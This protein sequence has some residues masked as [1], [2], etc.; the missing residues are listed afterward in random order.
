MKIVIGIFVWTLSMGFAYL[1]G[2]ISFG[3]DIN[4]YIQTGE[5]AIYYVIASLIIAAFYLAWFT[6]RKEQRLL[7]IGGPIVILLVWG[8]AR[9]KV[10][11]E[12]AG[13]M[14]YSIAFCLKKNYGLNTAMTDSYYISIDGIKEFVIFVVAI[15]MFFAAY[16]IYRQ[17]SL[18]ISTGL[19]FIYMSFGAVLDVDVSIPAVALTL[20]SII[21]LRYVVVRENQPGLSVYDAAGHLIIFAV[22]IIVAAFAYTGIY[23]L[24]MK[25]QGQVVSFADSIEYFLMGDSGH[26]YSS[27]YRINDKE[28]KT[29]DEVVDELV[30][31]VPPEGNLYVTSRRYVVYEDGVWRNRDIGYEVDDPVYVTFDKVDF[32]RYIDEISDISRGADGFSY[33]RSEKLTDYIRQHISYTVKPEAFDKTVDPVMYALYTGHQ[34]YCIHFATAAAIGLRA[35]GVQTR[36]STGYVVPASAWQQLPD[37]R[38]SAKILDRY[39]HAW[40]EAYDKAY[41]VWTIVDATPLGDMA[42]EFKSPDERDDEGELEK[43]S[44]I[45]TEATENMISEKA[46]EVTTQEQTSEQVTENVAYEEE[47]P[48]WSGTLP[49]GDDDGVTGDE[50][51]TLED[52]GLSELLSGRPF[53]V[54]VTILLVCSLT[55][56][57]ISLRRHIIVSRRRKKLSGRNRILSVYEMSHA[58]YEMLEFSGMAVPQNMDDMEYAAFVT[59]NCKGIKGDEFRRFVA[60][61]QAA[62]YGHIPPTDRELTLARRLYVKIRT[63]LYLECNMRKRFVWKY[64]KCYDT[65]SWRKNR[66]RKE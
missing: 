4:K 21:V 15:S 39:S 66:S 51:G 62:V 2:D 36:Y 12:G 61:V 23:E 49:G 42:D 54:F 50:G 7:D 35:M 31:D 33:D 11:A 22:C 17:S 25:K 60:I 65:L 30:R 55:F 18:M 14:L 29:T 63:Y 38:Y 9:R 59:E 20:L 43:P 46:T 48:S 40:I 57:S 45:T 3:S 64:I 47:E 44:E 10:L 32:G 34:G 13:G 56:L 26:G 58:I 5:V 8:L 37:G 28:V 6:L 27:Y 53:K 16:M 24:G 52:S 19:G 41:D 1:L